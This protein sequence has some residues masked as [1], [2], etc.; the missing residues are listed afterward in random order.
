M[1]LVHVDVFIRD[2]V[3]CLDRF[4]LGFDCTE[5]AT[6]ILKIMARFLTKIFERERASSHFQNHKLLNSKTTT[7]YYLIKII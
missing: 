5:F 3:R 2:G 7:Y 1:E 4:T 6:P